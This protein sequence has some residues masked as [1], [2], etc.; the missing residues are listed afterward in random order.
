ME[1]YIFTHVLWVYELLT[2][3]CIEPL[4]PFFLN[5]LLWIPPTRLGTFIAVWIHWLFI[6]P[7]ITCVTIM[8]H[9]DNILTNNSTLSNGD[10]TDDWQKVQFMLEYNAKR[11]WLSFF[12]IIIICVLNCVVAF[13]I[14]K[15]VHLIFRRGQLNR[16]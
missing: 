3:L 12:V 8:D 15:A 14:N 5:V 13:Y 4:L 9:I 6:E 2:R 16:A 1:A 7:L 10:G 11:I